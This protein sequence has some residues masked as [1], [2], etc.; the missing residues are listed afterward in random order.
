MGI[1]RLPLI[2]LYIVV[3]LDLFLLSSRVGKFNDDIILVTLL[4]LENY[5]SKIWLLFF[6]W[7]QVIYAG[8]GVGGPDIGCIF[9]NGADHHLI[10]IVLN[11]NRVLVKVTTQKSINLVLLC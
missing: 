6:G 7:T 3:I 9:N 1:L 2:I 11:R 5:C 4:N 8:V 10:T